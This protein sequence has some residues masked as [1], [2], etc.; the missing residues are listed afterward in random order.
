VRHAHRRDVDSLRRQS[1]DYGVGL[2]AYLT[3]VARTHPRAA[4][5]A[6]LRAPR[7]VRHYLTV[8]RPPG[9]H[10]SPRFP[11]SLV[12][13]ERAGLLAGPF[14]YLGSHRGARGDGW[15][16]ETSIAASTAEGIRVGVE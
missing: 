3:H 11:R 12:W 9:V 6:L 10:G 7:A 14:R 5:G 15:S 8:R 4:A 1:F 2:G 16:F 13:R